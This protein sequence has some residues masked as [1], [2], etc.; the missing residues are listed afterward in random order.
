M[1]VTCEHCGARYRL[2]PARIEGRGARIT[3]PRCR[4]VFVVYQNSEDGEV[5]TEAVAEERPTD[6]HALDQVG[7]NLLEGEDRHG[8]VYID[9]K[10]LRLSRR[11]DQ[12]VGQLGHDDNWT[13]SVT[14]LISRPTSSTSL[15][16][17]AGIKATAKAEVQEEAAKMEAV[18]AGALADDLLERMSTSEEEKDTPTPVAPPEEDASA[19]DIANQ[20]L[21]AVEAAGSEDG[22]GDGGID[23]DMDALLEQAS[24]SVDGEQAPAGARRGAE[25]KAVQS[26][27]KTGN[28]DHNPH[29]FVDPFESLRPATAA[30]RHK[31]QK[32]KGGSE[33]GGGERQAAQAVD[34]RGSVGCAVGVYYVDR[35]PPPDRPPA[36]EAERVKAARSPRKRRSSSAPMKWRG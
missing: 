20:L 22:G 10:T 36:A 2:D 35:A 4:H 13:R 30:E 19:D 1:V 6:V 15:R 3:C 9:Y 29:Q 5:A 7:R 32:S 14:S 31:R 23:L 34:P 26:V 12:H 33:E 25:Q 28:D 17:S 18:D 27:A 24:A 21:A 16:G 11:G 8:L